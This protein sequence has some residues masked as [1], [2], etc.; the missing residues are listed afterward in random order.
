MLDLTYIHG[1][2]PYKNTWE[3]WDK[4]LLKKETINYYGLE[5]LDNIA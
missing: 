5:T 2:D 1:Y 3:D 4:N